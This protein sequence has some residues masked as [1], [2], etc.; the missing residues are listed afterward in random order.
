ME[1]SLYI[2]LMDAVFLYFISFHVCGYLAFKL[3]GEGV[4]VSSITLKGNN[5]ESIAGKAEVKVGI[6]ADPTLS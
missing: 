6:D 2:L 3:Y 5:S 4:S 1:Y